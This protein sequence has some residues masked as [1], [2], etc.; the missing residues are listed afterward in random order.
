MAGAAQALAHV[1]AAAPAHVRT[2]A[3][4][5]RIDQGRE[6]NLF[7]RRGAVAA[8]LV[9]TTAPAPRMLVAFPAGDSGV[10]VWFQRAREPVTWT[11]VQAP[12]AVVLHD[13]EGRPLRGIEAEVA[14]SVPELH[15]E[16]AVLSSVRVIRR[17]ARSGTCPAQV[18]TAPILRGRA[19]TWARNRLDGAAGYRL[20]LAV[21]D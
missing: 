16:Q 2:P 1:P 5:F 9:L 4:A 14:A 7:L 15:V 8:H 11:V 3:L 20:T 19:L 21:L 17:Y 18:L 6:I 12:R 13:A 10:A